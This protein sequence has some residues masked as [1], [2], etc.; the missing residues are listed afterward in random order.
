MGV[1]DTVNV[2]VCLFLHDN[3]VDE[4]IATMVFDLPY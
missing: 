2:Y 4:F 1:L 3:L